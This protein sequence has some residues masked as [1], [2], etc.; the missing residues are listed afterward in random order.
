MQ[1]TRRAAVL[2][3][4]H[5]SG[6]GR[7]PP[8]RVPGISGPANQGRRWPGRERSR[9]GHSCRTRTVGKGPSWSPGVGRMRLLLVDRR[10]RLSARGVTTN[11]T[12]IG[13]SRR[14]E[15]DGSSMVYGSVRGHLYSIIHLPRQL[16]GIT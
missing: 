9:A 12:Y 13:A 8:A 7:D 15:E 11:S 4:G 10:Y 1:L 2:A 5:R 6:T 16:M 3:A 14:N